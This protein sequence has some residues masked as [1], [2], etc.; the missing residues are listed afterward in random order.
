MTITELVSLSAIIFSLDKVLDVSGEH[1]KSIL[2][3]LFKTC[4]SAFLVSVLLFD[5]EIGTYFSFVLFSFYASWAK[6]AN[7]ELPKKPKY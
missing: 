5:V 6:R 4:D 3:Y 2:N 7:Y 1:F